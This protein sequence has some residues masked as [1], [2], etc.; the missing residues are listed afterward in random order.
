LG[1]AQQNQQANNQTPT[2]ILQANAVH[3]P[4]TGAN[5]R[6]LLWLY[7]SDT[8]ALPL[9][10]E[11]VDQ[12]GN[13]TGGVPLLAQQVLLLPAFDSIRFS[14][15]SSAQAQ[16]LQQSLQAQGKKAKHPGVVHFV[17][18]PVLQGNISELGLDQLLQQA[19]SQAGS[20]KK[21]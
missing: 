3:L 15:V 19:Q 21:G 14:K 4:P 5:E 12:S 18:E 8:Q 9:G 13:L 7:K 16:Q 17:G 11:T 10:Q 20:G 6:Y 2:F 1:R